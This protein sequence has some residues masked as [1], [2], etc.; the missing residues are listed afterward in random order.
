[1][2]LIDADEL[3][4]AKFHVVAEI[5]PPDEQNVESYK[6]GWNDALDAVADDSCTL[7][8]EPHKWIP[9]SERLPERHQTVLITIYGTDVIRMKSGESFEDALARVRIKVRVSVGY[10]REE[11]WYGADGY[12]M[13]V[14]PIAWMPLPKP[15]NGGK[16]NETD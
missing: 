4:R 1:M 12:P 16:E 15:Y 13:I 3:Y 7:T 10:C 5:F 2:R 6:R 9:C 8:I 11:R 14:A